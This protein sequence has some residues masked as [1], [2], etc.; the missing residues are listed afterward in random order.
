MGLT[1]KL[2]KCTFL[3]EQ[4]KYL[5]FIISKEGLRPDPEKLDA[6][7]NAPTPENISQLK[8][9]LGMLNYYGKFIPNLSH[10]LHPLHNLLKKG[11]IWKWGASC[12][13]AFN[14]AK[15][16]LLSERVLAHYE[17]GRPLVLS[18]DSSAYGLGAVLAHRYPDGSERPVSCVSRTLSAA[19]RNYSQLD[20]EALAILFGVTKHHQYLFGRHFLLRTDHQPLAY[21]FGSKGGIP[22]TAASRLQRWAARL[23]AY[24]FRVEYVRS[25]DNGPADALSRLP[26]AQEGRSVETN[27]YLNLVEDCLPVNFKEIAKDTER[28][29][30]LSKIKGYVQFGWPSVAK[31]D[32]EKP[33]FSRKQEL[34]CELGCI[35]Y[36]Y[37]VVIPVSLRTR[38]LDEIHQGHLGINKMKALSRNY[39]YWPN[40]DRDLEDLCRACDACRVVRDAPPHAPLHPWEFPHYPWQRLHAD[41]AECAGKRY[42]IVVDA[43]SKWIEALEMRAT[44]ARTTIKAFRSIF[45]RFGLPSQLVTDNGPPFFSQEFKSYCEHNVIKHVT[46]APYRPQGNGAAENAVKTVKKAI[47]RALHENEDIPT[48]LARFLFQYRNCEHG[49]TGVAPA[50]A[51]LGRRL[52]GRLDALRPDVAEAVR[53]AQARQARAAAGTPRDLAVGD[54]VLTRDYTAAGDKWAEGVIVKKTGPLSYKVDVGRDAHWRRHADQI[55]KDTSRFSLSRTSI[56]PSRE[57]TSVDKETEDM[58]EDASDGGEE[59][60]MRLESDGAVGSPP[61]EAQRPPAATPSPHA[62]ARALRAYNRAVAKKITDNPPN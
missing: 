14:E 4:V 9:F 38:V 21:I 41:F 49:T 52:R 42:L 62:S 1:V 50:V 58:F 7:V 8:S 45:A 15:R 25:T 55:I 40:L 44:D 6:I 60:S 3:Q 29:R 33:F 34:C 46:S 12:K 43:H 56:G 13:R 24:D 16:V 54:R 48:A 28:D 30:L 19:E 47:K 23:A 11:V 57:E 5:G 31:C 53:A 17:E 59:E 2:S 20:K 18:V 61:S 35:M 39:I 36:K 22:Q 51:L 27:N 26:L 37:R 32:E 10:I